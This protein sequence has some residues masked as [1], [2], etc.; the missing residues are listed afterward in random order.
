M[1]TCSKFLS[2]LIAFILVFSSVSVN[3]QVTEK[4]TPTTGSLKWAT[5]ISSDWMKPTGFPLLEGENIYITAGN[6]LCVISR[7]KGEITKKATMTEAVGFVSVAPIYAEN[8][9][10]VNLSKGKVQAFDANTLDS[11][12]IYEDALGGQGLGKVTYSDKTIFTGF[13][14]SEVKDA[15]FV[16]LD[17]ETGS[18]KWSITVDGGFY[19]VG[20]YCT[21]DAVIFA[22][23]DG[24]DNIAHIYSCK[25]ETGEIISKLDIEN[26]G[27][28][29]SSVTFCNDRI[30][31]TS[32]GGY[33]IS[34]ALKDGVL[35]DVQY[36][37]IGGA[38]TSTPVIYKDRIYIGD[39]NKAISVFDTNSLTKIFS[40]PVK[41]Y[42]QCTPLI[43]TAYEES[44]GYLH[45]YTTYNTTPGGITLIKIKPQAESVEDCIVEELYDA[46]GYSQYC[47]SDIL[48]D[49]E[50]TLYYK[51]DSC[52]LFALEKKNAEVY[53]SLTEDGFILPQ[54][55]LKVNIDLAESYS[56]TD[57]VDGS[58]STLDVLVK[59]HEDMFGEDFTAETAD[60]YLAV[61]AEGWLTR[62]M[63]IDTYNFGFAVNGKAPHDDILTS[64][65]YT[66]YS[67]NQASVDSGDKVEF[68]LYRDDYAMDNYVHFENSG[69]TTDRLSVNTNENINLTLKGYT[70]AWY[71][72][73]EDSTIESM[74]G[75]IK[76]ADIT[77]VDPITGLMEKVTATD[78][79]G[80]FSISFDKCGTYVLSA[81]ENAEDYPL[82]A[83]WL[84][85]DVKGVSTDITDT[86]VT[87]SSNLETQTD[88]VVIIAA[89]EDNVLT[90]VK[91]ENVI[92]PDNY[93]VKEIDI[94]DLSGN[95]KVF[96][97]NKNLS[98][99]KEVK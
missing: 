76:G 6:E 33:I 97:W 96:I 43:S 36:G 45:L 2:I 3:A 57:A 90:D 77:V 5:L 99:I 63:G 60:S 67:L 22:T 54:T 50:G 87:L 4:M 49:S 95:V 91:T 1:K 66:G 74:T 83:P 88:A 65:G 39:S 32:K 72:C 42:P 71:S 86:T 61:S 44:T 48:T 40:V 16:A 12:W 69:K 98:P 70:F 23:D 81:K 53:A 8:T 73:M 84:V 46:E 59:I 80:N 35:S 52:Y 25:K 14:N 26:K 38:S 92:L 58:V 18:L 51:N 41:G 11:K 56:Y 62:V 89:Y 13:W 10:F 75:A 68:F 7:E 93:Y 9:V 31:L 85:I 20:A 79:N 29:R 21:D 24:S 94:S 78:E 37:E 30:Y 64:Y 82:I 17:S 47:I 27:D 55:Q 28:I 19:W 34:A 15:S